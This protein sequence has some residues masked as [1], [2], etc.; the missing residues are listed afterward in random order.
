MG[1]YERKL[2]HGFQLRLAL[3]IQTFIHKLG[4][5]NI[6]EADLTFGMQY[7]PKNLATLTQIRNG[8]SA[9]VSDLKPKN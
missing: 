5:K 8:L 2:T 3:P 6:E 1:Q 7:P 9:L 4:E